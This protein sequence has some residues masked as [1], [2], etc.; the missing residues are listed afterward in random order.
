MTEPAATTRRGVLVFDDSATTDVD[1]VLDALEAVIDPELGLDVIHLGL[2]YEVH[3]ASTSVTVTMTLTTPGCPLHG[4]I[5]QDVERRMEAVSGVRGV[6]VRLTW[7]PP[8]TPGRILP[9][10]R[11]RLGW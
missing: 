1:A 7:D 10:G 3:L 4:V 11:E 5:R 6:D 2:V 8:W 9:A